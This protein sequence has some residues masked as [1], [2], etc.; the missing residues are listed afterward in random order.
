MASDPRYLS[1]S[2]RQCF[3]AS[4]L[5]CF[6]TEVFIASVLRLSDS[7]C[8]L[9]FFITLVPQHGSAP[10]LSASILQTSLLQCFSTSKL[11]YFSASV[12]QSFNTPAL[13]HCCAS[14]F[15]YSSNSVF[16][17]SVVQHFTLQYICAFFAIVR[18]YLSPKIQAVCITWKLK[19]FTPL[20]GF[21][22]IISQ[23]SVKRTGDGD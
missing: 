8:E 9:H 21:G 1:T 15:Q 14:V 20:L 2:V 23:N 22:V 3:I 5:Q 6:S 12:L 7:Q 4:V 16:Q 13:Q 11:H 10:V 17:S 19:Y 18:S